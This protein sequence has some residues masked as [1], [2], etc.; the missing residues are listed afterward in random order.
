[1]FYTGG[2]AATAHDMSHSH[3]CSEL[4]ARANKLRCLPSDRLYSKIVVQNSVLLVEEAIGQTPLHLSSNADNGHHKDDVRQDGEDSQERNRY[5][6]ASPVEAPRW[7]LPRQ[8]G[9]EPGIRERP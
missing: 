7:L 6:Y 5:A 9:R 2:P 1:M 4:Q 3:H 8:P